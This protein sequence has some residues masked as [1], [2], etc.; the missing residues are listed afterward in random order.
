M[1]QIS[2]ELRNL[3]EIL[4]E[5]KSD[6]T[7]KDQM[8]EEPVTPTDDLHTE[9]DNTSQCFCHFLYFYILCVFNIKGDLL[10]LVLKKLE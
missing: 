4:S 3:D 10:Y 7:E 9:G 8:V 1:E 2:E 6:S 5:K